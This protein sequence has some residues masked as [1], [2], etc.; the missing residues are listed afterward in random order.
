ML[1]EAGLLG[2]ISPDEFGLV[3][4]KVANFSFFP[5][6]ESF[7]LLYDHTVHFGDLLKGKYVSDQDLFF[8]EDAQLSGFCN[9][10]HS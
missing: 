8:F 6:C 1:L 10:P 7:L 5:D 9:C 3:D 2:W 4:V